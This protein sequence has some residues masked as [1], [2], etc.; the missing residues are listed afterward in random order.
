V[1]HEYTLLLGCTVIT[2]RPGPDAA[3]IAWAA[4]TVLALGSEM[5]VRSI[6]RGDSHVVR[7]PGR[8]V[9][10][11]APGADVA[12]PTDA[13]LELGGPADLAVLDRD[14]RVALADDGR[15]LEAHVIALVRAGHVVTGWPDPLVA[16][17]MEHRRVT[18]AEGVDLAVDEWHPPADGARTAAAP[19]FVLVHGLASNAR[20]WDGVATALV[21]A[22]HHVFAVD[23][24]GHGRSSKPSGPYDVPTVAGDI[25]TVIERLGI[26]R[27]VVAGQSWGG[28]VVLELAARRPELVRGI[29]CVDGGWLEPSRD[30]ADWDACR[31]A[32]SPPRLAGRRMAEIEGYMR[33]AHPDWPETGIRGVLANFELHPD[34]TVA[35]WLTFDHHVKVLHGLWEHRPSERYAGLAV[36]VLLAPADGGES[37]RARKKRGDVDTAATII[38]DARVRWFIGDH[39]IH[40]Q[41][42]AELAGVMHDLTAEGFFA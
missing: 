12:W 38:P 27:P 20:L 23:L 37:D 34:G 42:P 8:F 1:T 14:P 2:G 35:P 11:L 9:V 10:P 40:A 33:S 18:V 30:F 6:S 4:D 24:R 41:H 21:A 28:N 32:L 29:V 17:A 5:E 36:P 39:D 13:I 19:P 31:A 26:E 3:A 16:D 15:S 25:A 7:F 22:G